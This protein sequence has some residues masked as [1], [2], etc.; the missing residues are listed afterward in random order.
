MT[1]KTAG[2]TGKR[3]QWRRTSRDHPALNTYRA[4][5]DSANRSGMKL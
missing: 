4:A 2:E 1:V 5:V 3:L